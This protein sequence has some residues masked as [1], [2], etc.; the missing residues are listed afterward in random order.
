MFRSCVGIALLILLLVVLAAPDP[1]ALTASCDAKDCHHVETENSEYNKSIDAC[2]TWLDTNARIIYT[3]HMVEGGPRMPHDPE[4]LIKEYKD[5]GK[6]CTGCLCNNVS[7]VECGYAY[8][9][10]NGSVNRYY[11]QPSTE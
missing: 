9:P 5:K 8:L 6:T 7:P 10:D 3:S 4:L 2:F 11:C 1:P